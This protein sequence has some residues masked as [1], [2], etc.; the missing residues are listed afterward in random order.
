[1]LIIYCS[2]IAIIIVIV[3]HIPDWLPLWI[4]EWKR[5][6]P[7]VCTTTT[8]AALPLQQRLDRVIVQ[9]YH[10]NNNTSHTSDGP[11]PHVT[12][13][14]DDDEQDHDILLPSHDRRHPRGRGSNRSW[15]RCSPS[16]PI[17]LHDISVRLST[18]LGTLL[19]SSALRRPGLW[20][21]CIILFGISFA[22]VMILLLAIGKQNVAPNSLLFRPLTGLRDNDGTP[23]LRHIPMGPSNV[24]IVYPAMLVPELI[25]AL[26]RH[27]IAARI[28][29]LANNDHKLLQVRT[30]PN[31]HHCLTL[32]SSC[33]SECCITII[34]ASR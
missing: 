7:A 3:L 33:L 14:D 17:S 10:H 22:L 4:A 32:L 23:G 21:R 18:T 25:G 27:V 15:W 9:P 11:S 24:A 13:D 1:M 26:R 29:S 31:S 19:R 5:P 30:A 20:L 12:I 16:S 6:L 34:D 8:S 2:I 28:A